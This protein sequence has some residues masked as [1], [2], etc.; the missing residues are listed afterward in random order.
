MHRPIASFACAALTLLLLPAC[1]WLSPSPQGLNRW[2]QKS[3][4]PDA[5]TSAEARAGWRLL[6]NGTNTAG[7]RAFGKPGFPAQ[8]WLVE[9]G[10]LKHRAQGGGGDILTTEKFTNFEL[11]WEWRIAAGANSGV[12]Y[13]IDEA[14]GTAI[15]HEYQLI[16][17]ALHPDALQGPKRQ[18]AALYD[19]LPPTSH[20]VR[21]AGEINQSLLLV[22]G[23]HVEHWL[24]GVKVLAYEIGSPELTA[25]KAQ[26]KFQHEAKWG[27]RFATPILL[28]DH[29]DEIWFRSLRLRPLD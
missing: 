24:N 16:D 23:D 20:P 15:G 25:A 2:P 10:W 5:L 4:G 26:S 8:G 18:T 13:F 22:R 1:T 14:R 28:Q 3:R 6:F 7:W 9:N 12:K 17:D 11:T 29:G 21:P 19:A 27:T